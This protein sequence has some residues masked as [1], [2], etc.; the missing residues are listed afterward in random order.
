MT[1]PKE[2]AASHTLV[3]MLPDVQVSIMTSDE[4]CY[5]PGP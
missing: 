5:L 4:S 3:W 1:S 2:Q